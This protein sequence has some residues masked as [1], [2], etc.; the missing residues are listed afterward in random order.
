MTGALGGIAVSPAGV[1]INPSALA[2]LNLKLPDGKF[3]IPTPQT[4]DPSMPFAS[5]G[6][7][8]FS[9]PCKFSEDQFLVNADYLASEKTSIATRVFFA[10]DSKTITFPGNFFNPAPNIRGFA[11]PNSAGYRVANLAYTYTFNGES[12]NEL[13][14]GYVRTTSRTE[15]RAPFKWSDVGVTEGETSHAN[16]LPNLDIVGSVALS[17]AFTFGFAQN[18][19]VLSD[20]FS[21]VHGPHSL[22]VGGSLTR[23]QDNF[24][25]PGIGSFVQFLSWPDFLLGLSASS[26]GTGTFSNV[27]A[28]ID[29]FGLFDREYRVWESSAFVQ[30]D[31]RIRR[32]LTL[33]A[34]L[35]YERLGQ[36]ADKLGRNSSFN[37]N[38]ADPDPPL[39]GSVAGYLVASNFPGVPPAGVLPTNN[40]FANNGEGQNTLSPRIGFAWQIAPNK[41]SLMLRGGYGLYFSRSTGQAFFQGASGAPFALLRIA[42]GT[43]NGG[44]TFESPFAQ[45]FPTP[46]SFPQFPEYS[47]KSATTIYTSSPEF[48]PALTQ[49]YSLNVQL[50]PVKG[51]LLE[52]AYVGTRVTG[53]QRVRSLNQALGATPEKPIR[54]VTTNTVANI[55]LRVAIAGIPADSLDLVES[56]G[57]SWY[58]GLELSLTKR[59]DHGLQML[60]SYTYSKALDTDGSNINGTSAGVALT[61]GN[62]N[63]PRQ[64]WG[65]PSFDRTHRLVFSETWDLPG[66]QA[67]VGRA[68]LGGWSLAGVVTI[69]SG[70]ALTISDTNAN[71]VFGISEDRAELTGTCA[72]GRLVNAGPIE[73]KL[74]SYFNA[75]CF[76]TPPIIGADGIGTGFGNSATGLV[77][78]PPQANMDVAVSKS[79]PLKW[80]REGCK[81]QLRAEFFNALNHPQFAN[82]D[83]NFTSP[84]FGVISSTSV[85]ARVGQLAVRLAF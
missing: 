20:E 27:F 16:E 42:V 66:P 24:S 82:P 37:I 48:R 11:S 14:F 84:S 31:F 30:D 40:A 49:Q 45:P 83:A 8:I 18:S 51:W 12:L 46:D 9:E 19:F 35:R 29:D 75:S 78:G 2:L 32:S 50:E 10:N 80:P 58:N 25:D 28:S 76:T 71:N 1:N 7:S 54:G 43:T 44:A 64:R 41:S 74:N 3:L 56:A 57:S 33:N 67:G 60:V 39:D 21:V 4:V 69:Q 6:S 61:L 68:M 81:I 72:K 13:R 55:P 59:M 36:F 52:A 5:Q 15:S 79:L 23:L 53:S 73:S 26:N 17:S 85:N 70:S 22:R 63:S 38:K 34:G 65:R 47:P 77:D 62:Q